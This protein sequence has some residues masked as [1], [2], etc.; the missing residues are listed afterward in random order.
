AAADWLAAAAAR[1]GFESADFATMRQAVALAQLGKHAEAGDILAGIFTKFPNSTRFALVLK[2]GH[3]LARGLIDKKPAEAVALVEKL[4]PYA[5]GREEAAALAMD[6][7]DAVAAIPARHA[8]SIALYGAV[9]NKFPKDPLAPQALYLAGYGALTQGDYAGTL[10]YTDAFLAAYPTHE[11]VP[12]VRYVAA[13]SRLQL[14]KYDEAE[15]LYAELL[16]KYPHRPDAESW[17]V[18]QA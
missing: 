3:A 12:D 5:E 17:Q 18:R 4:L 15:K 2:T 1:P 11:L 6:R 8:E 9:A 7:A 14:G 13:E 10:P 16:H